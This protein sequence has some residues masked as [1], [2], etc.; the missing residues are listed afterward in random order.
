MSSTPLY[1]HIDDHA[2]K[3]CAA[4]PTA[5]SMCIKM[6]GAQQSSHVQEFRERIHRHLHDQFSWHVINQGTE[7]HF[8]FDVKYDPS[9]VSM[10]E[11][12]LIRQELRAAGYDVAEWD[13][14]EQYY[15]D[16]ECSVQV[17]RL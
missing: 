14:E 7:V 16:I 8:S 4:F 15:L 1:G 2:N 3:Y 12:K 9:L 17:K 5:Q 11:L 13:H 10:E 6:F